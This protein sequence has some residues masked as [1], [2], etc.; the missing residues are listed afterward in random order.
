LDSLSDL[1]FCNSLKLGIFGKK[2]ENKNKTKTEK[3]RD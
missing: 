2:E 1:S 3:E